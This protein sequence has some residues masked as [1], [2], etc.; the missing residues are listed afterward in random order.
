MNEGSP[1]PT[2]P[3]PITQAWQSAYPRPLATP[4]QVAPT[5]GAEIP[6]SQARV[7]A[8]DFLLPRERG[9]LPN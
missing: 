9:T 1:M 6:A 7:L 4:G 5:Q 3:G 2:A 8:Q